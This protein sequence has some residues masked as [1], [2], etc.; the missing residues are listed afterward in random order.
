MQTQQMIRTTM[1][2]MMIV[3]ALDFLAGAGA[4]AGVGAG[5]CMKYPPG[6]RIVP[7]N[8]YSLLYTKN[9]KPGKHTAGGNG[10]IK[11]VWRRG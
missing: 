6:G 8:G 5:C 11:P 2:T 7:N 4:G 10:V 1:T 3:T 9:E